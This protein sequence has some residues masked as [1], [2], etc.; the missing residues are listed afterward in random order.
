LPQPVSS[1]QHR[2]IDLGDLG[3]KG[4]LE[5]GNVNLIGHPI[6]DGALLYLPR[7]VCLVKQK[8]EKRQSKKRKKKSKKR[9]KKSK[10]RK[11]EKKEG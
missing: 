9:K 11:K 3:V 7:C 10:K 2:S 8:K 5:S 4:V 6:A 1:K